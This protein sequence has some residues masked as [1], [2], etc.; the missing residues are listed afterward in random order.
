MKELWRLEKS[1]NKSFSLTLGKV[2]IPT[3]YVGDARISYCSSYID[4]CITI[5]DNLYFKT[6][7]V[8]C[9]TKA[10]NVINRIFHCFIT[11]NVTAILTAYIAYARPHLECASTVWNPGIESRGYIGLKLQLEKKYF[12]PRLFGHSK[13]PYLSYDER[14]KFFE[15]DSL[16]I[17]RMRFY[18][19]MLY[20]LINGLIDIDI[21][22]SSIIQ[23]KTNNITRDHSKRLLIDKARIDLQINLL[24][25]RVAYVWNNL[26]DNIVNAKT[27]SIF[28]FKI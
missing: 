5:D 13:I 6:H 10:Y 9:C 26:D 27:L 1:A 7:L 3:Y 11:N 22:P 19:I 16:E 20:K 4:V 15:I 17:R 14:I 24:K 28:K 12:T 8:V 23:I 18:L 25:N 2:T 21:N